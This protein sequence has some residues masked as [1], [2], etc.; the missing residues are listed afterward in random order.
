MAQ[1]VGDE[2]VQAA[3]AASPTE[4]LERAGAGCEQ[5]WQELVE[6]QLPLVQ[7]ICAGYGLQASAAAEVDQ[8]VWLQLAEHLPRFRSPEAIGGWIAA[9]TRSLCLD[10]RWSTRRDGYA[11]GRVGPSSVP[12]AWPSP[13]LEG[14]GDAAGA[15]GGAADGTRVVDVR[16]D[17][18]DGRVEWNERRRH[19]VTS[20]FVRV[21]A[22]CQRL[23]RLTAVA[24]DLAGEDI[25]AALDMAAD[26]VAPACARCLQRLSRMVGSDPDAVLAEL[27]QLLAQGEV[28][29]GEWRAAARVAFGWHLVDVPLAER[30]YESTRPAGLGRSGEVVD[31]GVVRQARFATPY[32]G[33][34][35]SVEIKGDDVVLT[36]QVVSGAPARVIARWPGGERVDT[37]DEAGAF[38][39]HDLPRAPLCVQIDAKH[40]L[41]TGWLIP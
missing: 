17:A 31:P 39:F 15:S 25:G 19:G 33:V 41:K 24:P 18:A 11:A 38:R 6:Q 5:S 4:L 35:L 32:D 34:E 12:S 26:R 37:T 13:S 30:V 22:R 23:L 14:A 8:V 9:T 36:G 28:V 27:R 10:P 1:G 2:R 21:G 29:P 20:A 3:C 40:A 7:A 16:V